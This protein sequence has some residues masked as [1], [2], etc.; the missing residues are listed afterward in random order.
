MYHNWNLISFFDLTLNIGSKTARCSLPFLFFPQHLKKRDKGGR[1]PTLVEWKSAW[2][3]HCIAPISHLAARWNLEL[4]M[5]LIFCL[6]PFFCWKKEPN[7]ITFFSK[8]QIQW[9]VDFET[10]FTPF[11]KLMFVSWQHKLSELFPVSKVDGLREFQATQP[12]CGIC[13]CFFMPINPPETLRFRSFLLPGTN[14][15]QSNVHIHDLVR[16]VRSCL[17][18]GQAKFMP[19]IT[20]TMTAMWGKLETSWKILQRGEA[21]RKK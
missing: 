19:E 16:S 8:K 2:F 13:H 1:L 6:G 15:A 3:G 4:P 11:V 21:L 18:G 20:T 12:I 5:A 14:Q 17:G 10:C 7:P 9:F